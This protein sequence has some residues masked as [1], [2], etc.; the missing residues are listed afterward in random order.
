MLLRRQ[1]HISTSLLQQRHSSSHRH[2]LRCASQSSDDHNTASVVVQQAARDSEALQVPPELDGFRPNVGCV[3]FSPKHNGRVF[4]AT[5]L[6]DPGKSWQMPQ[7][8]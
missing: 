4:A 5:R 2:Q 8:V 6:D 7:G 3:V 1:A